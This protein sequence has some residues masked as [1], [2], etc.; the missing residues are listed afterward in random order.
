MV[1]ILV[2]LIL[3]VLILVVLRIVVVA[4]DDD[5]LRELLLTAL[6][7]DDRQLIEIEDG[8]ELLDYLDFLVARG[9]Q[10]Q[11]PD[12][13]LTDVRMPGASG[14]Q[15]V[16][17]ARAR[18]MGCP[19]IIL[20]GFPDEGLLEAAAA[21][22]GTWVLGKPQPLEAIKAVAAAALARPRA[23]GHLG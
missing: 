17:L 14:L 20:T 10:T 4:E 5:D 18:G 13:I 2:I 19:V 7:G 11:L 12:L 1:V 3:A 6:A 16:G 8:A 21:V 22:G 23:S 9:V 15:V